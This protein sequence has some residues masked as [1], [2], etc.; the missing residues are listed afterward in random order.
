MTVDEVKQK[1]SPILER[2]GVAM[3][4]FSAA[5]RGARTAPQSDVDILVRLGRPVGMVE[6]MHLIHSLEEI[7]HKKVDLVTEQR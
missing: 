6:Y 5:L 4:A 7:P 3:R 1:T 2:H